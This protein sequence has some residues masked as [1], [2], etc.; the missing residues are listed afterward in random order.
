[1]EIKQK[2]EKREKLYL[3]SNKAITLIALVITIIILLILAG[4]TINLI[5][6]GSLID[7]AQNATEK[8]KQAEVEE[9]NNLDNVL[10][11]MNTLNIAGNKIPQAGAIL[12]SKDNVNYTAD[13]KGE[14][15]PVPKGFSYAGEGTKETGFVIKNDLDGNE[16]VWIPTD[17]VPY[18][19]YDWNK[20]LA[21]TEFTE[22]YTSDEIKNAEIIQEVTDSVNMHKGYYISRYE[23]GTTVKRTS[24]T[25]ISQEQLPMPVFKATT[26]ETPIYAYN[27]IDW[28]DAIYLSNKL[29]NKEINNV[30]SRLIN[31]RGWDTALKFI[32]IVGEDADKI[33][34]ID[35]KGKGWYLD[36]KRTILI[37]R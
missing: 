5:M 8:Y 14:K 12:E 28:N 34:P 24:K 29:Y 30:T 3:V 31:A 20:G 1:M 7:Q 22:Y 32:E 36:N 25:E 27:Y 16:F 6:N 9:L 19:T 23:A 10:E 2:K 26:V 15:I 18:Q 17:L 35:S 13:G 21:T 33:Y 4:V 11:Q 37:L